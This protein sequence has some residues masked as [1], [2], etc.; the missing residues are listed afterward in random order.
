MGRIIYIVVQNTLDV[1][2]RR[3]IG[4]TS[5]IISGGI[6]TVSSSLIPFWFITITLPPSL[7]VDWISSMNMAFPLPPT[8]LPSDSTS[9]VS[10]AS[11]PPRLL[12]RRPKPSLPH[13]ITSSPPKPSP[14][15]KSLFSTMQFPSSSTMPPKNSPP[16]NQQLTS[17]TCF[18]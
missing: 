2:P 9:A 12:F 16:A 17:S 13:P 18:S 1:N 3:K 15:P 6:T 11:P 4:M 10:T 5:P 14:P 8:S 7:S